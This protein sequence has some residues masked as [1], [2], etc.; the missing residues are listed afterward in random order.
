MS[1]E[2]LLRRVWDLWLKKCEHCEEIKLHPQIVKANKWFRLA[3]SRWVGVSY[4]VVL[5][6]SELLSSVLFHGKYL[7]HKG[8][9][10]FSCYIK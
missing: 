8:K 4:T 7:L 5:L 2:Q 10:N 3:E 1:F 9:G 6:G